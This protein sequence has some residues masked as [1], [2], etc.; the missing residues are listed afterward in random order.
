M[1]TATQDGSTPEGPRRSRW[2]IAIGVVLVVVVALI[3]IL[4][5]AVFLALRGDDAAAERVLREGK[6]VDHP[7]SLYLSAL[8]T[9]EREEA[10]RRLDAAL[11]ADA[12][13]RAAMP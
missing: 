12:F 10:L 3:G 11:A 4:A 6:H 2:P 1:T 13:G 8:V 7:W 5:L 9:P